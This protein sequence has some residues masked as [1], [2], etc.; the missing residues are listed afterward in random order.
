MLDKSHSTVQTMFSDI[1]GTY[2]LLNHVLSGYQDKLW[3]HRAVSRLRPR[4]CEVVLDLCCGTGDST[5]ELMLRQPHCQVVGADFAAPMLARAKAKG[6]PELVAADALNL[7]F[8]NAQFD[9]VSIA[10]GVRNFE[11]TQAGMTEI[12]RV[13]KPGGRL[14]VLE[15]MRPTS[16]LVQRAAGASNF[17]LA[18]LGRAISG[19]G[20]AY[21]YLPQSIGGF[22]TRR[23]FEAL[24]REVGFQGVRSFDHSL[25]IATSFLGRVRAFRNRDSWMP[26]N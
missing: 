18:P 20:S 1:A 23:E 26:P 17:V 2:D 5:R 4:R 6:L 11:N 7:P 16:N 21:N 10:F 22:Y 13:L 3:R 24:L 19:H 14:M 15:F 8:A 12:Y 25:G 9:A